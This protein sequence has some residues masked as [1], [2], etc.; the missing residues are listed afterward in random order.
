[1]EVNWF[2]RF[3]WFHVPVSIYG[4][5]ILF[6]AVLFCFNVFLAED[7]ISHSASDTLYAIYPYFTAT[8]LLYEWIGERTTRKRHIHSSSEGKIEDGSNRK[9]DSKSGQ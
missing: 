4:A 3:G 8:F 2:R 5:V 7:K 6:I 9:R 1:M